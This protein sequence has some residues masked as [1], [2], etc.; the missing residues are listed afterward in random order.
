MNRRIL[1]LDLEN[2]IIDHWSTFEYLPDNIKKIQEIIEKRDIDS[3]GIFSYAIW[4]DENVKILMDKPF[5]E[6]NEYFSGKLD[7]SLIIPV[8]SMVDSSKQ[9][10]PKAV[11]LSTGYYWR[12]F[13]KEHAMLD[14]VRMNHLVDDYIG[15]VDDTITHDSITRFDKVKLEYFKI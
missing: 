4:C 11:D 14:Y 13:S 10:N 9:I 8:Q 12:F 15:L 3:I 1:Y 2:T 7:R 6:I 5:K